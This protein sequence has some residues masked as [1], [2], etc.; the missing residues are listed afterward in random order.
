VWDPPIVVEAKVMSGDTDGELHGLKHS[1]TLEPLAV[2]E[3]RHSIRTAPTTA[4]GKYTSPPGAGDT[5]S[6]RPNA[7]VPIGSAMWRAAEPEVWRVERTRHTQRAKGS[8][9]RCGATVVLHSA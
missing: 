5:P 2:N 1:S 6:G 7:A 4:N 3:M 9:S 8:C